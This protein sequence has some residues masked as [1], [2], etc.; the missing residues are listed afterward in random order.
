MSSHLIPFSQNLLPVAI[1][2]YDDYFDD[3]GGGDGSIILITDYLD[4]SGDAIGDD[5][6]LV[7]LEAAERFVT[8]LRRL[9]SP[10]AWFF[11]V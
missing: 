5:D 1:I 8:T 10:R 9:E 6:D 3:H 7:P 2:S 11:N 4:D